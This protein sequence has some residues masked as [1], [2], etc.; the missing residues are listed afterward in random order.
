MG[1]VSS[2]CAVEE[3]EDRQVMQ[4]EQVAKTSKGERSRDE[5]KK[6][7]KVGKKSPSHR[8]GSASAAPQVTAADIEELNQRL[9]SG[10]AVLVLLQDG[11]RLQCILH[12]NETDNSLSISCEDK[13]RVIPLSDVKALLHTRD[14]LQRVETK[15]NLT[16]DDSC[17]ALHLLESGNCIPL[18]FDSV[19]EKTCF[20]ELLKKLKA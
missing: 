5:K 6:G 18:R 14:Q 7:E 15:A 2:C 13:V 1:A 12:Y 3:S 4:K 11:T 19:R 17:V 16:D 10:M 8:S 20:V 9:L